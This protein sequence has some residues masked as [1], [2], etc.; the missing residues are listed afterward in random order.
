MAIN[1]RKV[2]GRRTL[3]YRNFDDFLA[4]AAQLAERPVRTLGNWTQAQIYQ[5]LA[6]SLAA[7]IDG[8]D[9][10]LP[11]PAR[12]L[13]R[14]FLMKRYLTVALPAGFQTSAAFTPS[15]E[16]ALPDALA[17]L[18]RTVQRLQVEPRRA[19]HPAFGRLSREEWD[20]FDLR[21]AEMH[22]SFLVPISVVARVE[23]PCS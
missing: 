3:R 2:L 16:T 13:M 6:Q 10:A 9:F 8:A 20:Q 4:D 14:L 12:W 15:P 1:T 23:V 21:H 17:A 19:L 11:L 5:H 22:M 18:Q 7:S